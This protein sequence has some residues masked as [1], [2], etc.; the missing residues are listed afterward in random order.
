MINHVSMF[1][2]INKCWSIVE[3]VFSILFGWLHEIQIGYFNYFNEIL[4]GDL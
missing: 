1:V 3:E 4:T 2:E